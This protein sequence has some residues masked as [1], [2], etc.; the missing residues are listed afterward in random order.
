VA[1]LQAKDKK[2]ILNRIREKNQ[3][4]KRYRRH[5]RSNTATRVTST[6]FDLI[7]IDAGDDTAAHQPHSAY[8]VYSAAFNNTSSAD[9]PTAKASYQ[10]PLLPLYGL[11]TSPRLWYQE[12]TKTLTELG[13]H[14]VKNAPCL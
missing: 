8:A 9:S 1:D 2:G 14:E 4:E 3:R 12:L 6:T 11:K 10:H 13:L 5:Q 7:A